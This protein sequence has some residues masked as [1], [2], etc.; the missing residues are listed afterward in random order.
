MDQTSIKA[1]RLTE[2]VLEYKSKTGRLLGLEYKRVGM[3]LPK[4]Y[5]TRY[6]VTDDGWFGHRVGGSGV[7]RTTGGSVSGTEGFL[8]T[9]G[10]TPTSAHP[11]TATASGSLP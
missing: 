8:T 7:G 5:Q 1:L 11:A 4:H 3:T 9:S 10:C 2:A 6:P